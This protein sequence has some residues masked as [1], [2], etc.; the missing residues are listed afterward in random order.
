MQFLIDMNSFGSK[1]Q[2]VSLLNLELRFAIISYKLFLLTNNP[3]DMYKFNWLTNVPLFDFFVSLNCE[4]L[5]L[6][7]LSR[8]FR[9]KEKSCEREVK[10]WCNMCKILKSLRFTPA[11]G[12]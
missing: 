10:H 3:N 6:K 11:Q 5:C 1:D 12:L 4:N 7:F 9:V 8:Y 2:A